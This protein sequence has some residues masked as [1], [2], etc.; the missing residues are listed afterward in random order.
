MYVDANE[1]YTVRFHLRR[2][3]EPVPTYALTQALRR[4]GG[5][6]VASLR[7]HLAHMIDDAITMLNVPSNAQKQ[8]VW[9]LF[10]EERMD[11]KEEDMKSELNKIFSNPAISKPE[12]LDSTSKSLAF[13]FEI[14]PNVEP[15]S[16]KYHVILSSFHRPFSWAYYITGIGVAALALFL[17]IMGL[18]K[19]VEAYMNYLIA[20]API[21]TTLILLILSSYL[22]LPKDIPFNTR[23]IT[24][25]VLTDTLLIIALALL[26]ITKIL[27]SPL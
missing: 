17:V 7:P 11:F 26:V 8:Y 16:Y 23:L 22:I 20:T 4:I 10:D 25:L 14:N 5:K 18:L 6:K 15:I 24:F 1:Y 2:P 9:V 21:L 13:S 19:P 3:I 12:I 27:Y